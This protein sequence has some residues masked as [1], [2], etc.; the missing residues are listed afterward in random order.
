MERFPKTR[1]NCCTCQF[2]VGPRKLN[3]QRSA[4]DLEATARGACHKTRD[5]GARSATSNCPEWKLW[6]SFV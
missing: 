5:A 2:W 6:T 4:V 3:S 1:K